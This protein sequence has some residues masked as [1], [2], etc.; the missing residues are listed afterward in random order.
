[1]NRLTSR[2]AAHGA[3]RQVDASIRAD[4]CADAADAAV[5][6]VWAQALRLLREPWPAAHRAALALFRGLLPGIVGETAAALARQARWGWRAARADLKATLPR[7]YLERAAVRK[8]TE[9]RNER[10][11]RGS[12]PGRDHGAEV[13]QR[14]GRGVGLGAPGIAAAGPGPGGRGLLEDDSAPAAPALDWTDLIASSA[15]P[16]DLIFPPPSEADVAAVV[17]AG[18]WRARLASG[19]RLATPEALA[20]A[21]AGGLAA[22]KTQQQIARDLLPLVGGVRSSARRVAR[23]EGLRV[24]N[25]AQM[26]CH[27]Q[28]GDMVVGFMIHSTHGPHSRSWHQ[29]RSGTVYH[30]DPK[31]GEKGYR[32]MPNPPDEAEDPGERPPG[33]PQT[34]Q[35]CLCY[36][37]PVLTPLEGDSHGGAAADL[38]PDPA[39]FADWFSA[40]DVRRR[41]L[42]VGARRYAAVGDGDRGRWDVFVDPDTGALLSAAE[43]KAESPADR[44]VR[45]AKVKALIDRRREDVRRAARLGYV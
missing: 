12:A 31:P 1:M 20:S 27:R 28:L 14:A 15:D 38:E 25:A 19:T 21:L 35:N 37:T 44:A 24:A 10:L 33:T 40:A 8:I 41:R 39:V 6:R 2:L 11:H 17:Y 23:T 32:Q 42:A 22:G 29:L 34:A 18:D 26:A 4:A 16:F 5:R 36:L 13:R 7:A 30:A 45:V 43:L 3:A 9:G